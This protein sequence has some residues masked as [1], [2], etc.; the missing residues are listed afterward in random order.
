[1]DRAKAGQGSF[2]HHF[3]SKRDLAAH[4]LGEIAD[5]LLNVG[6]TQLQTRGA[7]HDRVR[8]YLL[9]ERDALNGCRVGRIA[10]DAGLNERRLREP[11]AHYFAELERLLTAL[12]LETRADDP[13]ASCADA[14]K[15]SR[16]TLAIV[17]GGYVLSRI[18]KDES[19]LGD[20]VRGFLSVLA[21]SGLK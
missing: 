14:A 7:P 4:V 2:Y 12:Y 13:A 17:Q 16:A 9:A 1:M 21:A 8:S 11:C 15:L 5:E 6:R 19:Y 20:A 18:Q 10:Y 3:R